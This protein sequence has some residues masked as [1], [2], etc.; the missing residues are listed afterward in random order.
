MADQQTPSH[1]WWYYNHHYSQTGMVSFDIEKCYQAMREDGMNVEAV[2]KRIAKD[3]KYDFSF[4]QSRYS[5]GRLEK[6]PFCSDSQDRM[7]DVGSKDLYILRYPLAAYEYEQDAYKASLLHV[8]E[9]KSRYCWGKKRDFDRRT[10]TECDEAWCLEVTG[11]KWSELSL[12]TDDW[13]LLYD[14]RVEEDEFESSNH[15]EC[16]DSQRVQLISGA[17]KSY[18]LVSY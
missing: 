10:R 18:N 15:V 7:S 9:K 14:A 8:L 13:E 3:G 17:G 1:V 2:K 12:E 16:V 4:G 11:K 6:I 5:S